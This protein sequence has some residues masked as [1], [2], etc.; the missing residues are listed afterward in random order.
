MQSWRN[1]GPLFFFFF[2]RCCIEVCRHFF[3]HGSFK[4]SS[5]H[6]S[7]I[8]VWILLE[9]HCSVQCS[10]L[11]CMTQFQ[12][13]FSCQTDGLIFKSRIFW[14]TA[15]FM[16]NSLTARCPGHVSTGQTQIIT[17]PLSCITVGMRF[18]LQ[19]RCV[20][21]SPNVGQCIKFKHLILVS[22]VKRTFSCSCSI[23]F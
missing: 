1:L 9:I 2:L 14:Y 15:E 18:F 16:V 11:C 6:F 21:F 23:F 8:K 17:T 22:S 13:S 20:W 4:V 10:L 19:R 3:M 5:Q 7:L 12:S